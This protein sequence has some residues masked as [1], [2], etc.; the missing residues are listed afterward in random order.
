MPEPSDR[1]PSSG[2]ATAATFVAAVVLVVGREWMQ[3]HQPQ[4]HGPKLGSL[5]PWVAIG[6]GL[7]GAGIG[8]LVNE[9]RTTAQYQSAITEVATATRVA[10]ERDRQQE[11]DIQAVR[12]IVDYLCNERR[13]DNQEAGRPVNGAPC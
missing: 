10:Q 11:S 6:I 3:Q 7:V 8:Y 12:R 2:W 5:A 9:T 1:G 4:R 13:R